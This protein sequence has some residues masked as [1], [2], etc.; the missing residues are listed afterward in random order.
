MSTAFRLLTFA[1]ALPCCCTLLAAEKKTAAIDLLNPPPGADG[2]AW[3]HFSGEPGTKLGDVWKTTDGVLVCKGMPNGYIYTTRDYADFMLRLEWRW[4]PEGKPGKGGVLLRTT[5]ENRIWPKCLEAQINSPDAGDFWGL[6]GF[7]LT[8]PEDRSKSLEHPQFGKLTNVKKTEDVE[9]PAGQWNQYEIVA[10]GDTVVLSI[11]G[12]E[13]NRATG[14]E[15]APGKI[16]LTAEGDEIHF[17]NVTLVPIQKLFNGKDLTGWSFRAPNA[18][19]KM[20][21]TFS[22]HDGV[23]RCTGKP[24]GYLQTDKK[25][26]DY[27]LKLQWRW[28]EDVKPGNNGVL[29]RV[30]EGEHFHGNVW[31]KCVEAQL[32]NRRAGD[33]FT[34]GQF[35]LTGDPDRTR[36]RY[37]A[38]AQPTNEK[39]QGQWNDYEIVLVGGDLTLK[40]NGLVQNVATEVL[41]T[42]GTI[43]LQSEGAPIEYRNIRLIPLD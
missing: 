12:K 34:I 5:G 18:D 32:A 41:Q 1:V 38:M 35:P 14:C 27:I 33:I 20:E 30:L 11:N 25:Y 4:P 19:A 17:R 23:L 29:V 9:K 16:L 43:A 31:P 40:V 10:D 6:G 26:T 42:P 3:K 13:V 2:S 15:T 28:P 24:A 8:G 36:G 7:R 21:D 37:T 39:P 22:V